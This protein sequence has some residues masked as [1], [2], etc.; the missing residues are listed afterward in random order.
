ME[1]IAALHEQDYTWFDRH[2]GNTMLK[3][4]GSV[5]AL[6][7]EQGFEQPRPAH[8]GRLS[9]SAPGA[10]WPEGLG[11]LHKLH[12]RRVGR[13]AAHRVLV[14]TFT[15]VSKVDKL[16]TSTF[17][18]RSNNMQ[19]ILPVLALPDVFRDGAPSIFGI[20]RACNKPR[21]CASLAGHERAHA[22]RKRAGGLEGDFAFFASSIDVDAH[23]IARYHRRLTT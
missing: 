10:P 8:S 1:T 5:V 17:K 7:I 13:H 6:D 12:G 18:Q 9:V 11:R 3:T 21:S 14:C 16:V 23:L 20:L 2:P 19:H 15:A 4:D 22:P